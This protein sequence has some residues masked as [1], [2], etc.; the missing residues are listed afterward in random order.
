M[1][2]LPGQDR[3]KRVA[4]VWMVI[5]I[6]CFTALV[7]LVAVLA[8]SPAPKT[9]ASSGPGDVFDEVQGDSAVDHSLTSPASSSPA[10]APALSQEQEEQLAILDRMR[11]PVEVL[12]THGALAKIDSFTVEVRPNPAILEIVS[13]DQIQSKFE[14]ILRRSGVRIDA[15]SRYK[16]TVHFDGFWDEEKATMVYSHNTTVTQVAVLP[17]SDG[18]FYLMKPACWETSAFGRAGR[19]TME[20]VILDATD[21]M[22]EKFANDYLRAQTEK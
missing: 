6:V 8:N 3:Y 19:R 22:A 18:N 5:A 1:K 2:S 17:R 16:A 20:R 21:E 13:T 4:Q 12:T 9:A 15:K 14:L 10:P 7:G 11:H